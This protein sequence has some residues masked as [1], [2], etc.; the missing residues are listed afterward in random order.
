MQFVKRSRIPASADEVFAWHLRPGA[1]ERLSPPWDDVRVESRSGGVAD[2]SRVEVSVPVG[3]LR[4]R[5]VAEHRHIVPGR[6]FEDVQVR[7]PFAAWEHRHTM[8]PDGDDACWLEDRID[9]RLPGGA[10]GEM[11]GAGFVERTLERVF[12][13][14]HRVTAA[15]LAARSQHNGVAPMKVLV[16][17]ASG[18]VGGALLPFLTTG[19]HTCGRLVRR[20]TGSADEVAWDI[21]AQRLD[22]RHLAG[23][24]AVVHLAGEN[25]AAGRW[26]AASKE[27]IRA[28][29]IDGTRLLAESLAAA[30]HKPKVLVCASAIGFYGDRGDE[31]LDETSPPGTG[32]LP[33][34]CRDWEA[35]A[36]PA[37]RAGIRVVH[38]R[39]GVIL[40]PAGGAL[41]KM[42]LPFR[43][44][45]GGIVGSGRQY[46]SWVALDDVLGAVRHALEHDGLAGP[47]N[48][49][50][51]RAVTNHEFTKTL[52]RVLHRPTIVPMPAFA[53][54]LALGEMAD[55]LLLASARI[56]PRR[57]QETGYAF[58][59]PELE[60]ALR[61]LLGR[62]EG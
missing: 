19:G 27:R 21:A 38:L 58:R 26:T 2:G 11:L 4:R 53:A 22:P 31:P 39:F 57:L 48:V 61:H 51:P 8:T 28:S 50:A 3:P 37:R 55:A 35:A 6:S 13:F 40:T 45:G 9:Y 18:L 62:V 54:R 56:A 44:G 23:Y 1:F 30:P 43:L 46:W 14:R 16:S 34:V 49:V 60:P 7:G 33:D 5:W 29:R 20:A 47:V 24:D 25:I 59:F 15:D 12:A 42:L 17:G 41:A 36:E 32:F 10:L 52:G